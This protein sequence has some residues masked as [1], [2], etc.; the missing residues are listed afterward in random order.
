MTRSEKAMALFKE[1][2]NCAQS[3]ACAYA[4]VMGLEQN[5]VAQMVSS[6]GGGVGM[7][8]EVCGTV[9][10]MVFVLGTL[11][12]YADPKDSAAKSAHYANVQKLCKEFEAENGSIVCRTL[13]GLDSK[14]EVPAGTQRLSSCN[15]KRPC[16]ELVGCAADILERHLTEEGVL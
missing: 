2:Y 1:G 12:G 13:L 3:V 7:M 15:K 10:G 5:T 9:S 11:K 4:D 16:V 6:I 14:E 8:R